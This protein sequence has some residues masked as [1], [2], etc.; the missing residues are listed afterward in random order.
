MKITAPTS[1][2]LPVI[3]VGGARLDH[4]QIAAARSGVQVVITAEGSERV[5]QSWLHGLAVAD[6]R[7]LY[8]RTTGV[9]ANRTVRPVGDPTGLARSLL[10]SHATSVGVPRSAERVRAMLLVRLNQLAAGGSG[11]AP[12]VVAGLCRMINDD[13]L[14]L[15]RELGSI[16]TADLSALASTALALMGEAPTSRPTA[17]PTP[18]GATDGLAFIS[19]NAAAL[20]DAALA[21]HLLDEAARAALVVA[22][23]TFDAV[24][25]NAECISDTAL[26]TTP[27]PGAGVVARTLRR[28]LG[29]DAR[30]VRRAG[31]EPVPAARIQDS[32]GLRT[33]PQTH[34]PV[35]DALT[36]AAVVVNRLVNAPAEN[37]LVFG[38]LRPSQDGAIAHHG[39]FHQAYLQ[40]AMDSLGVAVAQS[41]QLVL[42]RLAVLVEPEMTCLPPFLGNG[43]PGASGIMACE[44]VAASALAR[45]RASGSP[46]GLQTVTLSRGSEEDAS[47]ASL[48]ATQCLDM[49][50]S[51][52]QLLACELVAAVRAIR[53]RPRQPVTGVVGDI[54]ALCHAL[55]VSFEDRDLSGDLDFAN[56]LL[57]VLAD[58]VQWRA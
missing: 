45:I 40:M 29:V 50:Q 23:L 11:V 47:F 27:F 53:M 42:A 39:G 33:I 57:P 30:G 28:L 51:Y 26:L 46:A 6:D 55:P 34:G 37:P 2:P 18:F 12:A 44:Y 49:A 56:E 14:P 35:L 21:V 41:G 7:P 38:G 36:A 58:L 15:V 48:A 13:S 32:F 10:R 22:A 20:G 4:R 43:T 54:V 17:G 9:G 24:N 16:G 3:S 19:S 8:G 25:G 1:S 52:R 31:G 5:R